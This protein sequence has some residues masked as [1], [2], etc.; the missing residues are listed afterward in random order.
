VLTFLKRR[1]LLYVPILVGASGLLFLRTFLYAKIFP[2][3]SFGLLSQAMLVAST[4]TNFAGVGLQLLG[5]KLLPQYHARGER[6]PF[7]DLVASCIAACAVAA[8]ITAVVLGCAVALGW[9]HNGLVFGVALPYAIAQYLFVQR[10]IEV[11]SE[12]RFLDHARM[13]GVRAVVLLGAGVTVAAWS[14]SVAATLAVEGAVTLLI[15]APMLMGERGKVLLHKA[16]SIRKQHRWLAEN[17]PAALRLLWMNGS[18]TLLYA[19]DRWCGIALLTKREYGIFAL[20]LTIVTLFETLQLIVNVSAFPL[21]GRMVAHGNHAR[22]FRF[23]ILATALV[24]VAGILCYL[25]FVFLLDLLL[26]KYLPSYVEAATVIKL[27][28]IVGMLRLADFFS[29]YAVLLDQERRLATAYC[30]LLVVAV[31]AITAA[32]L[33]GLVVFDPDRMMEV[34][35]AI[36]VCAVVL[37]FG[38][39]ARASRRAV[40]QV[41][42]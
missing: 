36:A 25:P 1:Y 18:S 14:H 30:V 22:A 20:G 10:L 38:I 17:Y 39:A 40:T 15:A 19:V 11:K 31:A 35:V 41:A 3:E 23:A 9:L 13:S 26:N 28:V 37:N 6:E 24:I 42:R 7:D 12:L 2:V 8:A 32:N 4:F 5:H 33:S 16:L 29:S 34:S 21:M 27:A